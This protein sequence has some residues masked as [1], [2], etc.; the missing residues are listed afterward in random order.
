MV[1]QVQHVPVK[2]LF[3]GGINVGMRDKAIQGRTA[4]G[5][6]LEDP[7]LHSNVLS[8]CPGELK[9]SAGHLTKNLN[10]KEHFEKVKIDS[11]L[12]LKSYRE[13]SGGKIIYGLKN[14]ASHNSRHEIEFHVL[15]V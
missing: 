15:A 8:F 11:E 1:T 14:Q 7:F 2:K 9:Q 4:G 13:V 5:Q 3:C 6:K 12:L 10:F